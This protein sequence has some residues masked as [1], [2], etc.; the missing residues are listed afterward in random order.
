MKNLWLK[1]KNNWKKIVFA[2]FGISMA[3]AAYNVGPDNPVGAPIVPDANPVLRT[4]RRF[5]DSVSVVKRNET[6]STI[7]SKWK[8]YYKNGGWIDID[9]T[10]TQT[11]D[12]FCADKMP[13]KFC[14]PLRSTGEA[15]FTANNQYDI[16]KQEVITDAPLEERMTSVGVNDVAGQ[17]ITGNLMMPNGIWNNVQYVLYP[18]AY[19]DADLIYY[20][21]EG[22][23]PRLAQLVR[24]NVKPTCTLS[25]T[26]TFIS[27]YSDTVEFTNFENNA[28]WDKTGQWQT[29]GEPLRIASSENRGIGKKPFHIWDSSEKNAIP[30]G[31]RIDVK[32]VTAPGQNAYALTKILPC[33]FFSNKVYPVYTDT[34]STFSPDPDPETNTVDGTAQHNEDAL[35]WANIRAAAGNT[36]NDTATVLTC[37]INDRETAGEGFKNMGRPMMGFNTGP[38]I[39]S[40]DTISAAILTVRITTLTNDLGN[41]LD[42]ALTGNTGSWTTSL[43]SGDFTTPNTTR[44]ADTD[45]IW[46]N[47]VVNEDEAWTLNATGRGNIAKGTGITRF[48]ARTDLDLADSPVPT[49]T[50]NSVENGDDVRWNSS[51]GAVDPVLSVTHAAGAAAGGEDDQDVMQMMYWKLYD[52]KVFAYYNLVEPLTQKAYAWT[53]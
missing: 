9:T 20:V 36:I 4:E 32:I 28:K 16:F 14:A 38:T 46:A 45:L 23:A 25:L 49:V 51:D 35:T 30:E 29:N 50:N 34:V 31:Q 24:W 41:T 17:L 44:Q 53:L 37:H 15:V 42:I 22:K 27:K 52:M 5:N 3:Y 21:N 19:N 6:I 43:V 33:G 26:R 13:F 8:N 39:P 2:V 1:I 11:P 40:G 10:L 7:G 47:M 48:S 12:G 18:G